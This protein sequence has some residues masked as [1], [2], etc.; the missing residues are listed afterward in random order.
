[1]SVLILEV[2]STTLPGT[3][4]IELTTGKKAMLVSYSGSLLS[5]RFTNGDRVS[6][7]GAS[8][9]FTGADLFGQAMAAYKSAEA[10]AMLATAKE[11]LGL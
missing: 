4:F 6:G 10:K 1:M 7:L 9:A 2:D 3:T 5:I 11:Q 8:K